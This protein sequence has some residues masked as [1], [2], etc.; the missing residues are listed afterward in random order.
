M[1]YKA[2]VEVEGS[3]PWFGALSEALC[4]DE[5][6][7]LF[8]LAPQRK[9]LLFQGRLENES[10]LCIFA[11]KA[12]PEACPARAIQDTSGAGGGDGPS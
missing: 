1:T 9:M 3:V 11:T 12:L 6:S 10:L 2:K 8:L 7:R 5:S 4:N